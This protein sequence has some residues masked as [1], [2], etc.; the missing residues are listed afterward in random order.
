M[1]INADVLKGVG[2][3]TL[4]KQGV[5]QQELGQDQ[6]L[7]LMTTQLTKQ[8]PTKPMENTDFIAQMAQF[9][10]VTGIQQ[11][12]KSFD[13][14]ASSLS[15]DQAL[16]SASLVGRYVGAPVSEGLLSAGG[17]IT[18]Q[19]ELPSGS[20]SVRLKISEPFT[21][22]VI[23]NIDLGSRDQGVVP[24]SWDGFSDNDV[25][26]SPGLYKVQVEAKLD[27]NNTILPTYINSKVD[28]IVMGGTG[29]SL[30]VNLEGVGPVSFNQVKHIL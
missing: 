5:K 6:F 9:S 20:P 26:S 23:R 21:G 17:E 24:F 11:L 19:V 18:G 16:Q 30:Q 13:Q 15:S 29:K 1:T 4:E 28:S 10:T 7:K 3:S 2:L 8:L 14:F 22:E 25:L 12:Q 27:G